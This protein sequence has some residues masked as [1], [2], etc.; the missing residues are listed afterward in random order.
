MGDSG[1]GGSGG[2]RLGRTRLA[3]LLQGTV[4]L[5]VAVRKVGYAG[6]AL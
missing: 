2:T 6:V 4:S 1:W 3:P 5:V